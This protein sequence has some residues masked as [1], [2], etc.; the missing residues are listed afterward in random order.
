MMPSIH[1][2]I[3]IYKESLKIN[4]SNYEYFEARINSYTYHDDKSPPEHLIS[5]RDFY[6]DQVDKLVDKLFELEILLG[7]DGVGCEEG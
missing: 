4:Q 7:V 2:Q 5:S 6:K 3:K 1:D